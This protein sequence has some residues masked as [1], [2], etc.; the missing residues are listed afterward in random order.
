MPAFVEPPKKIPFYLRFGIWIAQRIAGKE[1]LPAKLLAWYP[2]TAVGSGILDAL[3]AHQEPGLD[4]RMLKLVRLHASFALACTFCIDM[5][6][7]EHGKYG[8]DDAELAALQGQAEID[9]TD[10]FSE[11]EKVALQY[12]RLISQSPPSFPKD[13]VERLKKNFSERDIVILAST[14]AQVNYWSRLIQALG[15]PPMGYSDY[16][17]L[18]RELNQE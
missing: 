14:V 9:A 18:N 12:A 8:I 10:T 3:I 11:R 13:F 16:C 7:F 6:F 1:L 2:K 15:S 17:D 4:D 5:N